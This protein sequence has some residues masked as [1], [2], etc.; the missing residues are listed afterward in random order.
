[1][2]VGMRYQVE[3]GAVIEAKQCVVQ[4]TVDDPEWLR[5]EEHITVFATGL[6][7]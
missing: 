1:V 4:K 3:S 6:H 2:E 5:W 7:F